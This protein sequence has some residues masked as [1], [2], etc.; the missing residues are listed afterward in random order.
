MSINII[1]YFITFF[2]YHQLTELKDFN[3]TYFIYLLKII[4]RAILI[5]SIFLSDHKFSFSGIFCF[6]S[7]PIDRPIFNPK[8][9]F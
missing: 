6:H 5:F 2:Y 1:Y 3:L 9:M 8:V 4:K 7:F